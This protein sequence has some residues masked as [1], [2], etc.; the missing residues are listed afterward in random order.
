MPT[1]MT[2]RA[3]LRLLTLQDGLGLALS[4]LCGL[5]CLVLPAASL[6]L[7][8]LGIG[9]APWVHQAF[10]TAALILAAGL[11]RSTPGFRPTVKVQGMALIGLVLLFSGARHAL[12]HVAET[13]LTLAGG[14]CLA[15]AHL[16]NARRHA[17]SPDHR[18]A[19]QTFD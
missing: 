1:L 16:L 18:H 13:L 3:S 2:S 8:L 7:P 19:S 12:P 11:F 5:H 6:V 17:R 10:A 4:L 14:T 9:E 15:T